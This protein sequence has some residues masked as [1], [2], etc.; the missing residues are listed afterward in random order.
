MSDVW[1]SVECDDPVEGLAELSDWLGQELELRGLVSGRDTPEPGQ[2]GSLTAVLVVA[3]G[4]GGALSVLAAS[5]KAFLA[6]PRRSDV[7]V[8][9]S[10]PDGRTV[11]IDAKRVDDVETLVREALGR[12]E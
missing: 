10:S 1:L 12:P 6:L 9:V 8:T 3:V 7:R 5:L 2:L 4:S 11:E